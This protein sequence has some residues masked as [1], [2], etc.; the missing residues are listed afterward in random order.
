LW[1]IFSNANLSA[2]MRS[3]EIFDSKAKCN[4]QRYGKSIDKEILGIKWVPDNYLVHF[5]KG[6]QIIATTHMRTIV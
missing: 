2:V 5:K 6:Y 1:R 4:E 3:C